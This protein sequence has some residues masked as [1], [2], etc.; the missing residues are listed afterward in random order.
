[1]LMTA[2]YPPVCIKAEP[3]SVKQY[4]QAFTAFSEPCSHRDATP[5]L[6]LLADLLDGELDRYLGVLFNV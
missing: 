1:M 5:M 3:D 4:Y 6:E 2:G